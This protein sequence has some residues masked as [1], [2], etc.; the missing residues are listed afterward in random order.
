MPLL[1]R[2]I[3]ESRTAEDR[4]HVLEPVEDVPDVGGRAVL[5]VRVQ[6]SERGIGPVAL[7]RTPLDPRSTRIRT[8]R[9]S[10][11][12]A[13]LSRNRT[14]ATTRPPCAATSRADRRE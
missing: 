5:L 2:R 11:S 13:R 12:P 10:I 9:G 1:R 4:A 14:R 7:E 3:S 8:L 6:V